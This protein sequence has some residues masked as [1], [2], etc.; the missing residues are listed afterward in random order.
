MTWST[1]TSFLATADRALLDAADDRLTA[2]REALARWSGEPLIEDRY[3]DWARRYREHLEGERREL[4]L[5][6][7][8]EL[9]SAGRTHEAVGVLRAVWADAP[10][11]EAVAG[12]LMLGFA[13]AGRRDRALEVFE[14]LRTALRETWAVDVSAA[15]RR[16]ALAVSADTG[17]QSESVGPSAAN[18]V[19]LH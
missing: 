2:L 19:A 5:A 14:H 4:A 13:A 10:L 3:C 11:D 7:S 8:A 6:C 18:R 1:P 17:P 16:I 9:R 15:T 12:Q